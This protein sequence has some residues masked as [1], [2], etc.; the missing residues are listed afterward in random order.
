MYHNCK[1]KSLPKAAHIQKLCLTNY[2]AFMGDDLLSV[3]NPLKGTAN[4]RVNHVG[5]ILQKGGSDKPYNQTIFE[6]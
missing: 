6:G 4:E 3:G 2:Y 1:G 5:Q